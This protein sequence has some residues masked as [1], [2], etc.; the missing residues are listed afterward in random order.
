MAHMQ[1]LDLSRE[2]GSLLPQACGMEAQEPVPL[3]GSHRLVLRVSGGFQDG[4]LPHK[5]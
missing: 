2:G 3:K 1:R 5:C 4:L